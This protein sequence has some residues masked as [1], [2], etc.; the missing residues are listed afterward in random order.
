MTDRPF[1]SYAQTMEDVMLWRALRHEAP[2]FYIDVGAAD[3]DKLSVTRAF[4][5]R[6]W[7]GLDV[8]PLPEMATRLRDA[9]PL[10]IV[11]EAA[12]SDRDGAAAFY[13]VVVAGDAGLSTLD[14][15]M[16]AGAGGQVD[17]LRVP[18]TTLA[19]LCRD[20][21]R[22]EVHFLKIDVEG[23]EAAVLR[24]MDFSSV[25]PWI[26]L[27]EAVKPHTGEKVDGEAEAI[28][29]EA[30]YMPVYFDG[31]NR[32]YLAQEHH[33]ALAE[34]F[35]VPPNPFDRYEHAD[36][37]RDRQLAAIHA[38][39]EAR[40]GKIASLEAELERLRPAQIAAP[41]PVVQPP[42]L[43]PPPPAPP[44]RRR[45]VRVA[46]ALVRPVVR[47][48]AWRLRTFLVGDLEGRHARI[49]DRLDRIDRTLEHKT[50][51]DLDASLI[52]AAERLLLAVTLERDA[53]RS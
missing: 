5:E 19:S 1:I 50:I 33:A 13:R 10:D 48:L 15:S 43:P 42:P 24:G 51:P 20:H 37:P 9:R 18:V 39:S 12:L 3:P 27:V 21:V 11:V 28:L 16:A 25:R 26:V 40:L 4:Y 23:A 49:I 34:H 2:G 46:W 41:A 6:G 14:Q 8:E 17:T 36:L 22:S 29:R 7:R 44:R 47:P 53:D 31:L 30:G 35:Q 45:A 52:A 38:L 32:F